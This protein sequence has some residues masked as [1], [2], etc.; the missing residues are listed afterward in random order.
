MIGTLMD[1][2]GTWDALCASWPLAPAALVCMGI[3]LGVGRCEMLDDD[4][5]DL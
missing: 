3:V 2:G 4:D 5:E 1:L